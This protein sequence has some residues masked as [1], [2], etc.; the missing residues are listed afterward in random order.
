M[1]WSIVTLVTLTLVVIQTTLGEVIRIGTVRPDL[2]L[3]FAVYLAFSVRQDDD[4]VLAAWV[5]GILADLASIGPLGATGLGMIHEL[6]EQ[7]RGEA[8]PRQVRPGGG[9]PRIGLQHNA[10][11]QIGWDEAVAAV[12]LLGWS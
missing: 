8:G 7:L 11:G 5:V 3:I 9:L 1:K 4:A 6:V 12:T 2:T 10:G